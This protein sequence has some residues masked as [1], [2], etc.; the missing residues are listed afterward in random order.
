MQPFNEGP[1]EGQYFFTLQSTSESVEPYPMDSVF[2]T[3]EMN[4]FLNLSAFDSCS[5][6][7]QDVG[8]STP[9]IEPCAAP[10]PVP[11]SSS[12]TPTVSLSAGSQPASSPSSNIPDGPRKK[13][14]KRGIPPK[15]RSRYDVNPVFDFMW[16]NVAMS[17]HKTV[18]TGPGKHGVKILDHFGNLEAAKEHLARSTTARKLFN[19]KKDPET[20][21]DEARRQR[22]KR[23]DFFCFMPGCGLCF[24]R[25]DKLERHLIETNVHGTIKRGFTLSCFCVKTNRFFFSLDMPSSQLP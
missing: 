7:E 22:D 3:R 2:V 18:H 19:A 17:H 12:S 14:T 4:V 11:S 9:N 20:R 16:E 6:G 8:T 1:L 13:V 23:R 24:E 15:P 5:D 21:G 10:V 25:G